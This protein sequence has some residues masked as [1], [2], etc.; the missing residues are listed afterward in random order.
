VY[1]LVTQCNKLDSQESYFENFPVAATKQAMGKLYQI[2][3]KKIHLKYVIDD[4][5]QYI[6]E[7]LN[8][9]RISNLRHKAYL[10]KVEH[11][12]FFPEKLKLLR[13]SLTALLQPVFRTDQEKS[14][15]TYAHLRGVYFTCVDVKEQN[16]KRDIKGN[17]GYFLQEFFTV[18]LPGDKYLFTPSTPI[19]RV[20]KIKSKRI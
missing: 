10:D 14:K 16:G 17:V 1:V 7:Q 8:I 4:T 11:N 2:P 19:K 15:N 9:L 3:H 13:S 5:L 18:I 6:Y 20:G 12:L